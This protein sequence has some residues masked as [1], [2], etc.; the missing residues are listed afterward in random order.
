VTFDV[1]G[2]GRAFVAG[3]TGGTAASTL[4]LADLA[5]G[6]LT[7][8]AANPGMGAVVRGIGAAGP[9]PDDKLRPSVLTS[10]DRDQRLRSLRRA[11]GLEVACG[12]A[13]SIR[14]VLRVG[15]R[16][17]ARGTGALGHA[18]RVRIKMRRTRKR[19]PRLAVTAVLTVVAVDAAGN[20]TRVKRTVRFE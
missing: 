8:G 6:K 10:I 4:F 12:E 18:G 15:R 13:C 7:P 19:A 3:R 16:T 11:V 1:A 9:V 5:S 14:A 20:R 2:D 17:M